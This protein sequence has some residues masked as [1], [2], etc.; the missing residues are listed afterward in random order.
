MTPKFNLKAQP[1]ASSN[2]Q[3]HS[4]VT[5]TLPLDPLALSSFQP[6]M[7]NVLLI[8]AI[9]PPRSTFPSHCARPSKALV[10]VAFSFRR[11]FIRWRTLKT[12]KRISCVSRSF[13]SVESPCEEFTEKKLNRNRSKVNDLSTLAG[14]TFNW[15]RTGS[16]QVQKL[17]IRRRAA[18]FCVAEKS[19]PRSSVLIYMQN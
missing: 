7:H 19:F 4:D 11:S 10:F 18:D 13:F 6:H 15:A 5:S 12:S 1:K 14:K 3:A 17:S 9:V 2:P 16:E 8:A